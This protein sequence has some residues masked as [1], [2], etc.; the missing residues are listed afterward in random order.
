MY[1][2]LLDT[3]GVKDCMV[4]GDLTPNSTII[5]QVTQRRAAEVAQ[6]KGTLRALLFCQ[7]EGLSCT[8]FNLNG[9]I[10]IEDTV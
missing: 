10:R 7:I 9:I 5:R 3:F 6:C 1:L 2:S 4:L 8:P